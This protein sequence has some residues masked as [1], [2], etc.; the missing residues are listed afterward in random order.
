MI[1]SVDADYILELKKENS[2]SRDSSNKF[3]RLC[4]KSKKKQKMGAEVKQNEH[5]ENRTDHTLEGKPK[6][7]IDTSVFLC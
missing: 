2:E 5:V 4:L 6:G 1:I 7:Q 3:I